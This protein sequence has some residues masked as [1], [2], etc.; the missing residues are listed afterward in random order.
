MTAP[1]PLSAALARGLA[2]VA[3]QNITQEYPNKLD[4][5]INGPHDLR[6]PRELH[7]VFYGSFDWHSSVHMFW[8]L[9]RILRLQPSVASA[10]EIEHIFTLHLSAANIAQECAYLQQPL[11]QSFE[12]TYGWAWLLKL[13]LE[14]DL[15]AQTLPVAQVWATHLQPLTDAF[16]ARYQQYLPL[17]QIPLRAGTHANSAFGLYFPLQ[18]AKQRQHP[19]LRQ[20]IVSK[21]HAWYGQDQRYP[22][23]Y[24]PSGD[25]FLS[26]GLIEAL[27]MQSVLDGCDY[28]DWWQAFCPSQHDM[29]AWLMPVAVADRGDPKMSHLDGLNLSRAWCWRMLL[30]SL[31]AELQEAVV[32]AIEAHQEASTVHALQGDYV[33]THWLASFVLLALTE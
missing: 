2:Q 21:A 15:L 29:Q 3:L 23:R 11:R 25:D 30:P 31:P 1:Q 19:A 17:A 32:T 8:S 20:L 5:V 33:G 12:R 14:L 28:A 6:S 22:A 10:A 27:L 16:I 9:A 7:P 13:Q 18:Y 24:E 26:G 4:H